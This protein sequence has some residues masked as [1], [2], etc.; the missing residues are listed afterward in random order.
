MRFLIIMP[1]RIPG[2]KYCLDFEVCQRTLRRLKSLEK[3]CKCCGKTEVMHRLQCLEK[4]L[5]RSTCFIAH[6][7]NFDTILTLVVRIFAESVGYGDPLI[8]IRPSFPGI[9]SRAALN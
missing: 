4:T 9:V 7:A 3:W 5:F 8:S 1:N 6:Q 2:C